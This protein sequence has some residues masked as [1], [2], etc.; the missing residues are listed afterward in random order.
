MFLLRAIFYG[1]RSLL[2]YPLRS[3]LTMLGLIFG[4]CSVI[5]MLAIGEG[6]AQ[7]A[8]EV[9]MKLWAINVIITSQKPIELEVQGQGQGS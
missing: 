7:Q 1:I 4:V 6:Q 2:L 5:A 9:F 8:D 3:A